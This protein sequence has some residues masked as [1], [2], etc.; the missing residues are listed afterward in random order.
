[1]KFKKGDRVKFL[2]EPGEATV[3]AVK[4][5]VITV[6][7]EH[8]FDIPMSEGDL[9]NCDR[10]LDRLTLRTVD[11]S[12]KPTDN[13]ILPAK[14]KNRKK[15]SGQPDL[16]VDL[17]I[18]ALVDSSRGLTNFEIVQ[19][20]M[21]VFRKKLNHARRNRFKKIVFIHGVGEGVLR[22]EIREELKG[23]TN[24]SFE[25]ADFRRYGQGATEV[26]LW[27]N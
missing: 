23:M 19:I 14:A 18:D 21:E 1:M 26:N 11:A 8:G 17:H 24:C 12:P 7:D 20:Q 4:G 15:R 6:R 13:F 16:E 10:I 27:Y 2:N 5:E 9:V 25:D 3:I 22:F